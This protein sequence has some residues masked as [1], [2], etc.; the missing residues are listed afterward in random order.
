[1]ES[2]VGPRVQL[3]PLL[4]SDGDA[5]VHA[6][7]DGELWNLPFTIVPSVETV[8]GYI[9]AAGRS[10]GWDRHA[11]CHRNPPAQACHWLDSLLEDRPAAQET[12]DWMDL[13]LGVV[14]TDL[15]QYRNQIPYA[16][17]RL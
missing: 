14:A 4:A 15:C 12:R 7:A 13:A 8:D 11:L 3:R 16:M 2:L 1:M 6:A 5:L 17:L 10:S 9:R